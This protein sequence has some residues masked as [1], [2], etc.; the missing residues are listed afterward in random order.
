MIEFLTALALNMPLINN[1]LLL[2][3][4]FTFAVVFW[5]E[6]KNKESKVNWTDL[7]T[8][9]KTGKVSLTKL[10]QFWGIALSSWIV[11][12]MVQKLTGDQ[13]ASMFV[14]VFGSWLT[15]LVAQ[16]SIR[17]FKATRIQ[18]KDDEK[19]DAE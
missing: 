4:F 13:I 9:S 15:F 19:K 2:A 11:I 5:R 3:F 8:D 1:L 14:V 7:L 17:A 10:G 6:S 16:S 18:H 12:Y